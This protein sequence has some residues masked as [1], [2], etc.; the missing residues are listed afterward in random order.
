M[1][2]GGGEL[3]SSRSC[4]IFTI[5]LHVH[6]GSGVGTMATLAVFRGPSDISFYFVISDA[7][8]R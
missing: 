6:G 7:D 1:G 4:H 3:G 2:D 8:L 5:S